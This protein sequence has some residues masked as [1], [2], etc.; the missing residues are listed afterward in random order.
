MACYADELNEGPK[1]GLHCRGPT[2]NDGRH[3]KFPFAQNAVCSGAFGWRRPGVPTVAKGRK[4]N[5]G[6]NKL[7][8]RPSWP[9]RVH[10]IATC[11]L[12][13][14]TMDGPVVPNISFL[15]LPGSTQGSEK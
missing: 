2:A 9:K 10:G 6:T 4:E 8:A 12:K 15:G 7:F 5:P 14:L 1:S 11:G 13:D 3:G